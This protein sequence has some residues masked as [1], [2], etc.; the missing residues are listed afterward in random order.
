[1]S[2]SKPQK[3]AV[4]QA[5]T[6]GNR[7]AEEEL[8]EIE[9]YFVATDQW[10]KV[11]GGEADIVY[12]PKGSGKS[13][14]YALLNKR[15][16]ELFDRRIIVRSAENVR[17]ATVFADVIADPPPTEVAFVAVWKLYLVVLLADTFREYGIENKN[18]RALV[19]ALEGAGLLKPKST[20]SQL[21]REVKKQIW[22]WL[23]PDIESVEWTISIDPTTSLPV[24]SRKATYR[25]RAGEDPRVQ[26][27]LT[28]LAE[29]ADHAL[30]A[31]GYKIWV[32]FDRLDVA[33]NDNPEIERNAL[34]ALF[35][36]YNDFKAFDEVGLK[37]F[38]RDDI[39][40]RITE[41]GFTEAS[42]ITKT[43]KISWTPEGLVNL[44]VRRLLNNSGVV[45]FLG[46][47]VPEINADFNLQKDVSARVLPK[48]ID[49]GK[50]P[51]TVGWMIN[52]IQDGTRRP[53]PREFIHLLETAR[54]EQIARL[55]RGESLPPEEILLD[56]AAFKMGLNEVSKVRYEQTLQKIRV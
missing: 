40:E 24:A 18:S 20:L 36:V 32:V 37:I 34:R 3:K 48:K 22:S 54:Q 29:Q 8:N 43:V 2:E 33:F 53:A 51:E 35:R 13:A 1:M 49:S 26:L 23:F 45:E 47:K 21:F 38:V 30:S 10:T 12:G 16:N 6:F 14:L 46:A 7:V 9:R 56:K 5:M 50:T 41:G 39:W 31:A 28:E 42:H 17:G 19:E 11:F 15:E 44:F 4:I 27:P 52:H 55:E 25:P